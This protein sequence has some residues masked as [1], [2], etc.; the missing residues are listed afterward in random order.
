MKVLK[1][2]NLIQKKKTAEHT[3]TE[4]QVLEAIKDSP[5]LID[6]HYGFQT[7]SRL[8]LVIDYVSG[9]ELF[10][11]LYTRENFTENEVRIYIA[12]IVVAL[13]QLHKMKDQQA[14]QESSPQQQRQPSETFK[15]H[16]MPNMF[17]GIPPGGH[18]KCPIERF[19]GFSVQEQRAMYGKSMENEEVHKNILCTLRI[20][21]RKRKNPQK[22]TENS[23]KR[24]KRNAEMAANGHRMTTR[25]FRKEE[26]C[27]REDLFKD[28]EAFYY[29]AIPALMKKEWKER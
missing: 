10:T 27:G 9:G 28:D 14:V 4:R 29:N 13:E 23:S 15:V 3:R 5:F 7:E 24:M 11:H 17:A 8:Y 22:N 20:Q 2:S 26:I 6:F 19:V 1:K 25:H 12:E 18:I 21:M 16:E